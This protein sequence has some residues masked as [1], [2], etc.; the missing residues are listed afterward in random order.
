MSVETHKA[1]C[2]AFDFSFCYD[3]LKSLFY[4]FCDAFCHCTTSCNEVLIL[5]G[6]CI[7]YRLNGD[8]TKEISPSVVLFVFRNTEFGF[9]FALKGALSRILAPFSESCG[10]KPTDNGQYLLTIV[11]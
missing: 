4:L 10:R 3:C 8:N 7:L 6:F 9:L 1:A 11:R 5:W 2:N